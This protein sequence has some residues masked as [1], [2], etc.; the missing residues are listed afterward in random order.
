MKNKLV[1]AFDSNP[2]S[3]L[4][5]VQESPDGKLHALLVNYTVPDRPRFCHQFVPDQAVVAA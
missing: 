5:E 4:M 2:A 1:E 3:I